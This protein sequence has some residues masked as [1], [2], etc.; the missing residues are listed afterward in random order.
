MKNQH[1]FLC[2]LLMCLALPSEVSKQLLF[3][4][5][6]AEFTFESDF[7]SLTFVWHLPPKFVPEN[8][9]SPDFPLKITGFFLQ[10]LQS[11]I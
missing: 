7:E 2:A 11:N 3:V 10:Q 4:G 5:K 8:M 6:A 1:S 9:S